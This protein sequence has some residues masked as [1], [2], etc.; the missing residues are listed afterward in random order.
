[1]QSIPRLTNC[2][3]NI[4]RNYS[5]LKKICAKKDIFPSL[6]SPYTAIKTKSAVLFIHLFSPTRQRT[7]LT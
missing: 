1:M 2:A 3:I 5:L 7:A 6:L 4:K